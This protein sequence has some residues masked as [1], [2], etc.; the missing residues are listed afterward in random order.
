MGQFLTPADTIRLGGTRSVAARRPPLRVGLLRRVPE[1]ALDDTITVEF[2][3]LC[4]SAYYLAGNVGS[5]AVSSARWS[6]P[7][8]PCRR[9]WTPGLCDPANRFE[10]IDGDHAHARVYHR[11]PSALGGF[12]GSRQETTR[13]K[14][15]VRTR[16][17]ESLLCE[18]VATR[19]TLRGPYCR[20]IC[21]HKLRNSARVILPAASGLDPELW[22]PALAKPHFPIELWPAQQRI[23]DAGL[24]AGDR[25]SSRCR[26]A[27]AKRARPTH[28][29]LGLPF[30]PRYRSQLSSRPIAR[31]VMISVATFR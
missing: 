21:A 12:I 10:P 18:R 7:A 25:R 24:L 9:T 19:A 8:R 1:R 6:P 13:S 11:T 31:S 20:P 26:R 16:F 2:S 22:R 3:L 28:H 14:S 23:A 27:P 15:A 30:Q 17:A 4:A 5:A 29:P